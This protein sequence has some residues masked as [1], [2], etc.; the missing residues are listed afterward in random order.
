VNLNTHNF[1]FPGASKVKK[2]LI[3]LVKDISSGNAFWCKTIANFILINGDEEFIHTVNMKTISNSLQYLVVC[4]L[5][6]LSPDQQLVAKYASIIGY[7]FS[8]T[9]LAAVLPMKLIPILTELLEGDR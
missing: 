9:V 4:L 3:S 1:N 6:K 2:T 8:E 7:E 5:E